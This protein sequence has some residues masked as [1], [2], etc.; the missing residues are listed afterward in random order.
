M[1]MPDNGAEK[2]D[3]RSGRGSTRARVELIMYVVI[4]TRRKDYS[5]LPRQHTE[6]LKMLNPNNAREHDDKQ[7]ENRFDNTIQ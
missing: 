5:L 7:E 3:P 6:R 4:T 1:P 2:D